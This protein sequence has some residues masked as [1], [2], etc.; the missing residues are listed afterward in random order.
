MLP[1]DDLARLATAVYGPQWQ[2]ALARERDIADRQVRRWAKDGIG[3]PS[4]A[5]AIH[6]YLLSRR[7]IDLPGPPDSD[8]RDAAAQLA[9]PDLLGVIVDAGQAVG[10]HEAELLVAMMGAV[11]DRMIAGAG[12]PAT[13]ETLR[14]VADQVRARVTR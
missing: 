3:K 4:T 11:V 10:W 7:V 14:G 13:V 2:T 1:G 5:T 12:A 6:A 9:M 8:A